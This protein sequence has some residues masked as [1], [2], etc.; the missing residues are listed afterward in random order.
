MRA[1]VAARQ[2]WFAVQTLPRSEALAKAHLE[3]QGFCT[4]LPLV[5]VQRRHA[6][7][8]AVI[9]A[10]LFPRYAFVSLDLER[11]RWRSV[12][13]TIGVASLVMAGGAPCRVPDGIVERI[14]EAGDDEG[15]L[16]FDHDFKPGDEVRLTAGPFSG[17]LGKLERLDSNGRVELLLTLLNGAVRVRTSREMLEPA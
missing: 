14:L 9:R 11:D 12:N 6:H 10:P 15:V 17:V 7:R 5:V 13:G 16:N 2:R 4:F 1:Q 8:S 3:R